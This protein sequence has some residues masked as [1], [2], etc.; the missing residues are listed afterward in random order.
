MPADNVT[1]FRRRPA[2]PKPPRKL[3]NLQS[4]RGK[5]L[6]TQALVVACFACTF[7]FQGIPWS[8]IGL[9]FGIA[10]VVIAVTNRHEGMPWARTHHEHALRTVII[11]ASAWTLL[12]LLPLI[13]FDAIVGVLQLIIFWGMVVIAI[14]T[15][16]RALIG[17]GLAIFRRPIP[18]PR[19]LLI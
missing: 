11:G 10:A 13:S 17:F 9:G 3:F 6:L 4:Q 8:F 2:P 14:W 15:C 16:V 18:N 19:G 7:F 12:T 1:P 5:A